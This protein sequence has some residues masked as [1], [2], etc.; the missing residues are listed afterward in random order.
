MYN[1]VGTTCFLSFLDKER[2]ESRDWNAK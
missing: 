2:S 1:L